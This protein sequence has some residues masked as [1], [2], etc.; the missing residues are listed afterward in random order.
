MGEQ[1]KG[2]A[3]AHLQDDST[4][5]LKPVMPPT[6]SDDAQDTYL[7]LCAFRKA[8][9]PIHTTN[10]NLK[11]GDTVKLDD[12]EPKQQWFIYTESKGEWVNE[13]PSYKAPSMTVLVLKEKKLSPVSDEREK[14]DNQVRE[15]IVNK[16]MDLETGLQQQWLEGIYQQNFKNMGEAVRWIN[17]NIHDKY[18]EAIIHPTS[19]Q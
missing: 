9:P 2:E 5:V 19:K 15:S 13:E 1:L 3:T 11:D 10:T 14:D 17:E 12:Y 16:I 8:N 6:P 18:L 4:F 7:N